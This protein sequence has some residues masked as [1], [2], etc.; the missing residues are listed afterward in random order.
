[1]KKV[2]IKWEEKLINYWESE[3]MIPDN[4]TDKEIKDAIINHI[5]DLSH[6]ILG[7][8]DVVD[9]NTIKDYQNITIEE[10]K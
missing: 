6:N 8:A 9:A 4:L 2:R 1:M 10:I 7:K 5:G 3:V